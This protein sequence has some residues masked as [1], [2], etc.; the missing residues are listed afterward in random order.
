MKK[1]LLILICLCFTFS[2][3]SQFLEWNSLLNEASS[4]TSLIGEAHFNHLNELVI[5]GV[6][7]GSLDLNPNPNI[8][9]SIT[10]AGNQNSYIAK[11]DDDGEMLFGGHISGIN[12]VIINAMDIDAAGNIYISGTFN[13]TAD[14]NSGSGQALYTPVNP[15]SEDAFLV[16]YSNQGVFQWARQFVSNDYTRPSSLIIDHSGNIFIAGTFK[17]LCDFDPGSGTQNVNALDEDIFV[18]KLNSSG[19]YVNVIRIG[20]STPIASLQ[21][22]SAI[23]RDAA[24]NIYLSG[25]FEG[26][27]D[28]DPSAGNQFITSIGQ[29]DFYLAR[30]TNAL[31]LA[32]VYGFGSSNQEGNIDHKVFG[33]EIW[34]AGDFEGSLNLDLKSG[35]HLVNSN[36]AKD[37]FF[38]R[39]SLSANFE[40]AE[41]FGG[42][43]ND[44]ALSL[45]VFNPDSI[46]ITGQFEGSVDFN[47][48]S[49][50]SFL[51]SASSSK[52][53]FFASYNSN[54]NLNAASKITG[55]NDISANKIRSDQEGNVYVGGQLK[56]SAN[57]D[58]KGQSGS[59][60]S[61]PAS[62]IAKYDKCGDATINITTQD[63]NCG[64]K[65]GRAEAVI[66]GGTPPFRYFWTS[67][68]TDSIAD[69]LRAGLYYLTITDTLN[70]TYYANPVLINEIGGP[71]VSLIAKSDVSCYGG[72]N[73]AI[74]LG[75]SGGTSP[76][77]FKWSNGST[78]QNI[79]GLS[80][81]MYEVTVIDNDL[82]KSFL[83]IN[84]SEPKEIEIFPV[85]VKPSCNS[86]N[87]SVTAVVSGGNSPYS[88]SWLPSGSGN[89]LFNI[90]AGLYTV[91]VTDAS[92]CTQSLSIPVSN[93][94]AADVYL[95]SI[96]DVSCSGGGG[97]IF[98]SVYGG[99]P[100]Y[101]YLWNPGNLTTQDISGLQPGQYNLIVTD[102]S[103][104]KSVFVANV[105]AKKPQSPEICIVDVDS[106]NGKAIVV[107]EKPSSRGIISHY[108][109][110][111]ETS[112]L[113]VFDLVEDSIEFS[114]LSLYEDRIADTWTRPWSYK[115]SLTDTC[116][117][118]SE[119]SSSHTTIHTVI[120]KNA[121]QEFNVLW[122]PY[123]G[124]FPVLQYTCY[125]YTDSS[126]TIDSLTTVP[127]N[128]F[129]YT[130]KNSPSK[131]EDVYYF[132]KVIHPSGCTAT[133]AQNRNSSRSNRGSISPPPDYLGLKN[134]SFF[135][136]EELRISP[137]PNP[138]SFS[139]ELNVGTGESSQLEIY[140]M[141]GKL[142]YN[143]FFS[144]NQGFQSYSF[145]TGYLNAGLYLL[146]VKTGNKN[147]RGKIM[148]VNN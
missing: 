5:T 28:F 108:N 12:D 99:N 74:V 41:S 59:N 39:Y 129:T 103:S 97:K 35:Q 52:S 123:R 73:G 54:G 142:V 117:I 4:S 25:R 106:V 36:G 104:C 88:Y 89:T 70:C 132:I 46:L 49:T 110:Y 33:S 115:I 113:N 134:I 20:T 147:Y 92:N 69:S 67:G 3:K 91:E 14:L 50:V 26:T 47:P 77:T 48:S 8:T 55:N 68:S 107:W 44:I 62:F 95:D 87:G 7:T 27:V 64:I 120:T 139:I 37:V 43:G 131:G 82:C 11:Y 140:S 135:Q 6:F 78:A 58:F 22:V 109:V 85:V 18:L 114:E 15:G 21:E 141:D 1:F 101:S 144:T 65:D 133:D 24:G 146:S 136:N 51:L 130:D 13:N 31:Q 86:S 72:S 76:Y 10:S 90:P 71:V 32:W 34:I 118:E 16:K 81:G 125:R 100:S 40:L 79:N 94:L 23:D 84:I 98:V 19:N 116:G 111:R 63:A 137:N 119:K 75:V 56:G 145:N 45:D 102:Q 42:S 9:H 105:G 30:Y 66:N 148:I 128:I 53:L 83:R 143:R 38:A 61:G 96:S 126:G 127:A 2:G 57:F 138:G 17:G 93:D 124:D 112:T 121:Q 29:N 122:S 60:Y 80:S